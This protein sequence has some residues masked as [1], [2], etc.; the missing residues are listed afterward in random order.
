M[1]E[2]T[3]F[4]ALQDPD[5][6]EG[7]DYW[8]TLPIKQQPTWPDQAAAEAAS[9]Y[10]LDVLVRGEDADVEHHLAT[11]PVFA[12][13][14]SAS[15][16]AV[17]A[18]LAGTFFEKAA[19]PDIPHMPTLRDFQRREGLA[20]AEWLLGRWAER[21]SGEPPAYPAVQEA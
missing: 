15:V 3:D 17:L 11:H 6:I 19:R 13:L 8:R 5:V 10:L 21:P 16:D 18:G 7:L 9:A 4:V 12:G 20:A 14:P 1:F 2:S